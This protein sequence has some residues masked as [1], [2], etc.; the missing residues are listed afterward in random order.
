MTIDDVAYDILERTPVGRVMVA[1]SD[2]GVCHVGM[3]RSASV[4]ELRR[5]FPGA[6]VRRDRARTAAA[7]EQLREYFAGTRRVFTVPVDWRAV[8]SPFRRRVLQACAR[9]PAGATVTYGELARAVGSPGAARAVGGAMATNPV[10]II[11]PC[12]RVCATTGLG[13]FTGGLDRKRTLLRHEG[14][15]LV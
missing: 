3:G 6:R 13:G 2:R 11:V 14:A 15:L 10:P 9:V 12:H 8:E 1:V 5:R 4:A 7:R